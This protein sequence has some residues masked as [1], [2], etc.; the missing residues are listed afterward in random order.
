MRNLT[1]NDFKEW[2]VKVDISSY[3]PYFNL[4]LKE[5]NITSKNKLSSFFA[6]LLHESGNFY[7]TEEIASGIL[8]EGRIDLGNIVKN[9]GIKYKGLT[10]GQIT[11]R[12]NFKFFTKWCKSRIKD[13]NLDF[14]QFPRDTLKPQY[15]VL[16]SFWFWEVNNLNKYAE[17]DFI[18]VCSIWNT[19][20][21][22][23]NKNPQTI[24]GLDDRIKKFVIVSKWC[25][26]NNII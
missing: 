21:I 17:K 8:Y 4:Y 12:N 1:I 14:E 20:R 2:E 7:Y 25:D 15:C 10:F 11:G 6:N 13:F 9:D 18:N 3:L 22:Q 24:N 5:F 26:K 16:A 23:D 19:G